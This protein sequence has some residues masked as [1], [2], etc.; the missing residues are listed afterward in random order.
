MFLACAPSVW[1]AVISMELLAV[2]LIVIIATNCLKTDCFTRRSN[3]RSSC[4][5]MGDIAL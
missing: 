4:R 2:S 3:D 5:G 1:L